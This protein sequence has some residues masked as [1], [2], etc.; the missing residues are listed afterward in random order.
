[1]ESVPEPRPIARRGEFYPSWCVPTSP[2]IFETDS[3]SSRSWGCINF[4]RSC[5]FLGMWNFTTLGGVS[6]KEDAKLRNRILNG[7]VGFP[8][9]LYRFRFSDCSEA[10]LRRNNARVPYLHLESCD[11]RANKITTVSVMNCLYCGNSPIQNYREINVNS[12]K[13]WR[14]SNGLCCL[15]AGLLLSDLAQ[16]WAVRNPPWR[17]SVQKYII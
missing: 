6:M 8:V 16:H 17:T 3:L 5:P 9:F 1:M 7:L 15:S 2:T 10:V 13:I 14:C 4:H 11:L 12:G